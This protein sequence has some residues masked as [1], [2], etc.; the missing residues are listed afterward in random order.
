M[1]QIK[2]PPI[3]PGGFKAWRE[4]L[5]D[6]DISDKPVTLAQI[7]QL[8]H[9]FYE[10]ET[11]RDAVEQ[12]LVDALKKSVEVI[13]NKL[14]DPISVPGKK[15][16]KD[17]KVKI[18]KYSLRG[19]NRFVQMAICTIGDHESLT[20]P[21]DYAYDESD[22]EAN[23]TAS[24]EQIMGYGDSKQ[25][26]LAFM[27]KKHH[28]IT[29]A[30]KSYKDSFTLNEARSPETPIYLSYIPDDLKKV[31]AEPHP[32]AIYY[33]LGTK[34]VIGAISMNKLSKEEN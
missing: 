23:L 26:L 16:P 4:F 12:D 22:L 1:T 17:G 24:V 31:E 13:N 34:Q 8:Y 7:Y 25:D 20:F 29:D 15:K 30:K 11:C 14:L 19:D 5:I 27:V 9:E 18:K 6:K 32:N 33:A 10:N 21:N 28:N 2:L 3:N